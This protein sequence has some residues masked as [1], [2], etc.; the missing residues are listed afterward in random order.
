MIDWT[1]KLRTRDGREAVFVRRAGK[2]NAY[3]Y[4]AS[5]GGHTFWFTGEGRYYGEAVDHPLDLFNVDP[6]PSPADRCAEQIVEQAKAAEGV[7]AERDRY[8]YALQQI[9]A[10]PYGDRS[11]EPAM[12]IA[13]ADLHPKEADHA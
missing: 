6:T 1:G 13:R 7:A 12:I 2:A 9:A 11:A 3:P 10:N 8:R 5:V 4:G